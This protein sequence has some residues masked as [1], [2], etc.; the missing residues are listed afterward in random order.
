MSGI[1]YHG[2]L[3]W[4][5]PSSLLNAFKKCKRLIWF[6]KLCE[7]HGRRKLKDELEEGTKLKME[8]NE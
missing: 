4:G 8:K 7:E 1:W 2:N 3:C 6:C 5:L